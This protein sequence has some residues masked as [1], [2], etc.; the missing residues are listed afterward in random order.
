M[1]VVG[2]DLTASRGAW[3]ATYEDVLVLER[4]HG[5]K[6]LRLDGMHLLDSRVWAA[7]FEVETARCLDLV[8]RAP[9][10]PRFKPSAAM[11]FDC[12]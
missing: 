2:A 4:R 8:V 10:R 9:L 3:Q 5:S 7:D 1:T 6:V 12:L 11:R